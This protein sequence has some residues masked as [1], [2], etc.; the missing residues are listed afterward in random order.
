MIKLIAMIALL[1]PSVALADPPPSDVAALASEL[2]VT[3]GLKPGAAIAHAEAATAAALPGV[4]A[5]L[6]VA[7]ASK[8][9]SFDYRLRGELVTAAGVSRFCGVLQ[10]MSGGSPR[11]CRELTGI[12]A[13]YSAG[14]SEIEHWLNGRCKGSMDCALRAH[15]CGNVGVLG[16]CAAY[17][18]SIWARV[19]HL[20]AGQRHPERKRRELPSS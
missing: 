4:S 3:F 13:G 1:I 14:A 7:V 5:E 9:S 17:P 15:G 12:Q 10:A 8:E 6:L 16:A 19:G 2:E 18:A 11:R 20:R